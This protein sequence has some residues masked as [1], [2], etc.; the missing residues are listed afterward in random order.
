MGS[1]GIKSKKEKQV[2]AVMACN[3]DKPR[4]LTAKKLRE[5]NEYIQRF[6]R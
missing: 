3:P 4:Q 2:V 1:S 5:L 6:Y